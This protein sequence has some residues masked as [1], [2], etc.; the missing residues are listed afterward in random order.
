ME[1]YGSAIYWLET[2]PS[3]LNEPLRGQTTA[4]V[5]IVGGGYTGLWTAYELKCLDDSID[6]AILEGD[7]V[8]H[9]ASGRNGGFAMTL[10]DM[11]LAHLVR[12]HGAEAARVAHEAVADSVHEIGEVCVKENIDC[13]FVGSGMFVVST[14]PAQDAR[15]QADIDAAAALGLDGIRE[16]DRD[17]IQEEVHSPSYRKAL[18][19]NN[20]AVLNPAKLARGLKSVLERMGVRI[21]E[22]TPVRQI[23]SAANSIELTTEK[24]RV[25]AD[26]VVLATNAWASRRPEFKRKVVP[27]YTY[28]VL[29]EPLS[30][31]QRASIGWQGGQ[32]VE[33]KRNYVHYYRP[34]ADGRILWGGTDG[35]VYVNPR[36]GPSRDRNEKVFRQLESTFKSTF[37]QLSDVRFTHRWGGPVAITVEFVPLFGTLDGGRIHYGLGY[38]GHG[39]APSHTG[40]RILADL[41]LDK[42]RGYRS[43]FFVES[44]EPTF[45]PEPLTWLGAGLTRRALKRQDRRMDKGRDAGEM[46]PWVLRVA[47]KLG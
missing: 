14:N 43:L 20:C 25:A 34:T 26:Q 35:V 22:G 32:G 7:E 13:D 31:E 46:D 28:I 47:K 3:A 6:I 5:A 12:N 8:G 27:L 41:V 4:D 15:V 18:F 45:P 17:A 42:D 10:L 19:D 9:G 30:D 23:S 40:G 44:K 38:N 39:V 24:G 37:P 16:L 11:S 1:G 36:I 21:Y 33:D 29:T 2:A